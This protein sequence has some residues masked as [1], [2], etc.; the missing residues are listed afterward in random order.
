ML[1]KS[2]ISACGFTQ[3]EVV[4]LQSGPR[5]PQHGAFVAALLAA[6]PDE[7]SAELA[8]RVSAVSVSDVVIARGDPDTALDLVAVARV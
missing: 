1:K 7:W 2:S 3:V 8:G 5:L 4:G 6:P